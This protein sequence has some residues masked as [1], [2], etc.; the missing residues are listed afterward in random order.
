[1]KVHIHQSDDKKMFSVVIEG[2]QELTLQDIPIILSNVVEQEAK[3][4][5]EKQLCGAV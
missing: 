3:N 4:D 2:D 1:M 5:S